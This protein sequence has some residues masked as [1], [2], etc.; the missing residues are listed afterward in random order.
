M[1]Q[2]MNA[3]YSVG[4]KVFHYSEYRGFEEKIIY[5]VRITITD[6]YEKIQYKFR[7]GREM[8]LSIDVWHDED[9]VYYSKEDFIKKIQSL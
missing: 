8:C 3:K 2:F 5:G 4:D 9:D 1:I 7:E 6:N